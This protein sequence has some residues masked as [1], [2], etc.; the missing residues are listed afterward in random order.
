ME[1]LCAELSIKLKKSNLIEKD[2]LQKW[3]QIIT[4]YQSKGVDVVDCSNMDETQK[5]TSNEICIIVR[6]GEKTQTP[7][8]KKMYALLG[9]FIQFL[10]EKMMY[11]GPVNIALERKCR[12]FEIQTSIP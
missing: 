12:V 10:Y 8:Y 9:E 6:G 4:E 2:L 7:D 11:V 1:K 3:Q 5:S